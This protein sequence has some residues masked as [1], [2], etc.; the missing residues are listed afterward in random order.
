MNRGDVIFWK[1]YPFPDRGAPQGLAPSDKLFVVIG[2]DS[3][4][5]V[6]L[7]RTTSQPRSDRPDT[8]GCHA[9]SS[10]FRF[11]SHLASFR[12]PTW[13]QFEEFSIREVREIKNAGA[14]VV[15]SLVRADIQAIINCFK[16]SPELSN[17]ILP[18]CM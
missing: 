8:D 10:V 16:K 17:W 5:G 2:V 11:N 12:K 6:L 1:K 15:F 13:V 18:Y 7:F 4:G 9:D 3:N 14:S